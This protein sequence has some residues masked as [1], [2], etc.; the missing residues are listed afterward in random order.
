MKTTK[1]L[2]ARNCDFQRVRRI[3]TNVNDC[4]EM[5]KKKKILCMQQ[6]IAVKAFIS[7]TTGIVAKS[8]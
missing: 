7:S 4:N 8:D 1:K 5:L 3:S 6:G 2:C